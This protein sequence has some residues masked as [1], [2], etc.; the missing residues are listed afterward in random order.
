MAYLPH[1]K[2]ILSGVLGDTVLTATEIWSTG[3]QISDTNFANLPSQGQVDDIG[4]AWLAAFI[5]T[6]MNLSNRAFLT[7][8]Q[9]VAVDD[10]GHWRKNVDGSYMQLVATIDDG[11]GSAAGF[12]D[13][14]VSA[15][16]SLMTPRAGAR[17][18]GRMYWPM[19]SELPLASGYYNQAEALN[20][21]EAVSTALQAVNTA[22]ATGAYQGEAVVASSA[23]FLSPINAVRCGNVHDTQRRRRNGLTE[24]YSAVSV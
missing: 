20:R 6:D 14:P 1:C 9:V 2:V 12:R 15:V 16:T 24:T 21:A 7:Q 5:S 22:L 10:E 4:D 3:H 18:R 19:P 11:A 13:F 17:G 8:V 23:G